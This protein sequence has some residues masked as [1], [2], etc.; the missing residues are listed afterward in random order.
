[1]DQ[2]PLVREQIEAGE[3][4][5]A[6]F[7]TY[8]PVA[9]AF[10]AK[11]S[12]SGH[13][14]LYIASEQIDGATMLADYGE[15]IRLVGH[16]QAWLDPFQVKVISAREPIGRAVLDFV[17]KSRNLIPNKWYSRRFGEL[18]TDEA[19]IYAVPSATPV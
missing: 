13:W 15:V 16:N 1:M 7:S 10:W 11:E 17:C 4:F 3:K 14:Y 5:I 19:Y 6:E 8:K 2:S 9:A 12:D 18:S